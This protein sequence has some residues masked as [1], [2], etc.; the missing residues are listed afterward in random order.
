MYLSLCYCCVCVCVILSFIDLLSYY[1]GLR[2]GIGIYICVY[3]RICIFHSLRFYIFPLIIQCWFVFSSFADILVSIFDNR[4]SIIDLGRFLF[5][6][7]VFSLYWGNFWHMC[8]VRFVCTCLY[9][10]GF[11]FVFISFLFFYFLVFLFQLTW[12]LFIYLLFK[13]NIFLV[14]LGWTFNCICICRFEE[15][16]RTCRNVWRKNMIGNWKYNSYCFWFSFVY[17][18]VLFFIFSV[19]CI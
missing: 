14:F 15:D 17:L 18:L 12:A 4:L 5:F 7:F 10:F 3:N 6:V 8:L 13:Y 11:H 1:L 19:S 16:R 2:K 9:V